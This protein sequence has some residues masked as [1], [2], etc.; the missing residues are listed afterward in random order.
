MATKGLEYIINYKS[1]SSGTYEVDYHIDKE[2]F[3]MFPDGDIQD[4]DVDVKVIINVSLAALRLKFKFNGTLRVA[5]DRCLDEFDMP[6]KAEY[7]M[8]A[9]FGEKSSNPMEADD[10]II[11][12]ISDEEID[13]RQHIYE[14]AV[15]SLPARR[16]HPCDEHGNSMC[17]PEMLKHFSIQDDGSDDL[18]DEDID[19]EDFDD[20]DFDDEE[21]DDEDFTDEDFAAL[22]AEVKRFNAQSNDGEDYSDEDYYDEADDGTDESY[23]DDET[24]DDEDV[25]TIAQKLARDPRWE[26]IRQKLYNTTN[27]K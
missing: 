19:D 14:Y 27:S 3:E 4:G 25:E 17:N 11:L 1:L 22:E 2:F 21:F 7:D 16:I 9:K 10:F 20:E 18:Y 13:L 12:S 5:C 15:L 26:V 6:V 24:G 23:S 8:V